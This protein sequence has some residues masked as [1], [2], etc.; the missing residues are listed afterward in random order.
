MTI[1]TLAAVCCCSMLVSVLAVMPEKKAAAV[2][3]WH[4]QEA[5]KNRTKD[6]ITRRWLAH[7]PLAAGSLYM[8]GKQIYENLPSLVPGHYQGGKLKSAYILDGI[9]AVNFA[10]YLAG[11]PDDIEPDWSLA[12]Q[13]QAA[14]LSNAVID[15]LEHAPP[16][17]PEMND[18]LYLLG[19]QG[20]SK[21]NLHAGSQTF[22]NNVLDY[23]GDSDDSN[24][25]Q[26]GHR[27]WILNPLM[28]KT[29]FGMV[30]S[31]LRQY[32][33]PYSS[34]YAVS[35]D[36][37]AEEISFDYIAWPS[38]G[39]FPTEW[40][41]AEDA[42]SVSINDRHFD[43]DRTGQ[44]AVRMVRERDGQTWVFDK[45]ETNPAANFFTVTGRPGDPFCIIFR[46][47]ALAELQDGDTYQITIDG[48]YKKDGTSASLTYKTAFFEMVPRIYS[49]EA[50]IRLAPGNRLPLEFGWTKPPLSGM[51]PYF[52]SSNPDVLTVDQ[53]GR[54]YAA[55]SGT[56]V[57]RVLGYFGDETSVLF[58]IEEPDAADRPS[59]WALQGYRQ[60]KN[61]GFVDYEYDRQ[62]KEE[63]DRRGYAVM[64]VRLVER[65]LDQPLDV[66]ESPFVDLADDSISK[67][68]GYGIVRGGS[69]QKF[70][71]SASIS[72]QEAAVILMN[73]YDKLAAANPAAV[74]TRT[75]RASE[76]FAD[77]EAIA[78]W[79][80]SS[81][82]RAAE[83]GLMAG[84][85]ARFEPEALLSR[86]EAFILM[87][88]LYDSV[89]REQ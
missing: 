73:V 68:Y 39:W 9:H 31:N 56:A 81:V 46:P 30:H 60:A 29:M 85:G 40:F 3:G 27:R 79:A 10:R 7:M 35:S 15:R 51:R 55:E 8:E 37:K 76:K 41:A 6:E 74:K 89:L 71:S 24:I 62:Y 2:V 54:V 70:N 1:R 84:K 43:A 28:T 69:A 80:R 52:D 82:Y 64:A 18:E 4:V 38:A 32:P 25:D 23:M 45:Q 26:V 50:M 75:K 87:V 22:Y 65:I 20:A 42:W 77:D 21:S 67:A 47:K 86:E 13:Q 57:V 5:V 59:V 66:P 36:R 61:L 14:A 72:R 17:V 88:R 33:Y 11:L 83:A 12:D 16:Q 53:S 19:Y 48:L 58:D 34:M 44:I 63:I 78:A 49:K